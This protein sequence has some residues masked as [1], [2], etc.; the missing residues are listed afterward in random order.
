[1]SQAELAFREEDNGQFQTPSASP[2]WTQPGLDIEVQSLTI[3]NQ[4]VRNRQPDQTSSIGSRVTNFESELS[5]SW[6]MTDTEWHALLPL[7]SSSLRG[8]HRLASTVQIYLNLDAFDSGLSQFSQA[9]VFGGCALTSADIQY[10]EGELITVDATIGL[11][12]A[13]SDPNPS[14][15]TQPSE[16]EVYAGHDG[17]TI[18]VDGVTQN[19]ARSA[20]LSMPNLAYRS[21]EA[22][23]TPRKWAVAGDMELEFTMSTEFTEVDQ[24]E[25]AVGDGDVTSVADYFSPFSNTTFEL[26]NGQGTTT[27][28]TLSDLTPATGELTQVA[29]PS[30]DALED[31]TY[32]VGDVSV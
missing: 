23:R 30:D 20:T 18:K 27:T 6:T 8:D 10:N 1:M 4:P 26:S 25:A 21:G 19:G 9:F 29:D 24:L 15:I 11:G 2:S 32:H 17:T 5:V 22:S 3:D 7:T 28:Y 12:E 31:L 16:G 13:I 14:S